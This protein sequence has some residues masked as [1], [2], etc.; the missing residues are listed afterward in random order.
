[1]D[2]PVIVAVAAIIL[3]CLVGIIAAIAV[4]IAIALSVTAK[5]EL[6]EIHEQRKQNNEGGK[7]G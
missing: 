4:P 1:M 3:L 2:W 7:G 5:Y 6:L